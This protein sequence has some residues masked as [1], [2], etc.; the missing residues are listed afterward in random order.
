MCVQWTFSIYRTECVTQQCVCVVHWPMF[1][2]RYV[3][4]HSSTQSEGVL[5][6]IIC[7]DIVQLCE[8]SAS[9]SYVERLNCDRTTE[10]PNHRKCS[11]TKITINKKHKMLW[12]FGENYI[13][14]QAFMFSFGTPA[15]PRV[16][17]AHTSFVHRPLLVSRT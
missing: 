13:L 3:I 8:G 5:L 12:D 16:A 11:K 15:R 1:A 17:C 2:Y 9:I 6:Y 7:I 4:R 10:R 14:H